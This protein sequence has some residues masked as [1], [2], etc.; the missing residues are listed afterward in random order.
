MDR[1]KPIYPGLSLDILKME[2]WTHMGC[3]ANIIIKDVIH[4]FASISKIMRIL[5]MGRRNRERWY[6]PQQ[7]CLAGIIKNMIGNGQISMHF[8]LHKWEYTIKR[9]ILFF[10]LKLFHVN[11]QQSDYFH[12]TWLMLDNIHSKT[13]NK[14]AEMYQ[15][16]TPRC[17]K[18]IF[19]SIIL[20]SPF[21]YFLWID[22]LYTWLHCFFQ[23]TYCIV[24]AH[25]LNKR[26]TLTW[27]RPQRTQLRKRPTRGYH[28][29][30]KMEKI[31]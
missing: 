25:L 16:T 3:T 21:H 6:P 7:S 29:P 9:Q 31:W 17:K 22:K 24:L 11:E 10:F 13:N 8:V 2:S 30:A 27:R 26:I 15:I 28:C 14:L 12:E 23:W 1:V 18:E 5:L 4:I 19:N 20:L